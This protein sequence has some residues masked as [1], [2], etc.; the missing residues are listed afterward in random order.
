M[1]G[2]LVT[3]GAGFIGGHLTRRL[4]ADGHNVTVLD[5]LS[6]GTPE[7]V[8]AEAR[9]VIGSVLDE[10]LVQECAS[11]VDICYHLAAI[12]SV[13]RCTE[14]LIHSH[15]VNATG[16]VTIISALR[17]CDRD[18][19]LVYASSAAVYG[20]QGE[21]PIKEA[22]APKPLSAYGAD[23]LSCE[24]HAAAAWTVFGL[25][26]IGLR[27]F[28]VYGVGQSADS[29]YSGVITKFA[30][31]LRTDQPLV[32]S[33]DGEQS[34]DFVHVLDVVEALCRAGEA[35]DPRSEVLNVCTGKPTNILCLAILMSELAART[36]RPAFGPARPGDIK[37]SVGDPEAAREALGFHPTVDLR[38]GLASLLGC[39]L[40]SPLD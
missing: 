13:E 24:L 30:Q 39:P 12:A 3:G 19:R 28:N 2:V 7:N 37:S 23:K 1:A 9:L 6:S 36:D 20:Q 4:I 11:A 33:G 8:P 18:V 10:R 32:I 38:S 14:D 5:D 21:E 22:A 16:Q 35:A 26:S 25:R 40:S 15:Q 29:P 17:R 34:R 31:R 27:F